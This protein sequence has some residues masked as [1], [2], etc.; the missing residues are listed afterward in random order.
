M[1][2]V[3]E[4]SYAELLKLEEENERLRAALENARRDLNYIGAMCA[5]G[6]NRKRVVTEAAAR[7]T[8]E[9]EK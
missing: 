3:F 9:L 8:A 1:S 4:A 5:A 7:V 6:T 2:T